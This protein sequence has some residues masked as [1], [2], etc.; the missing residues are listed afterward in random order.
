M[1]AHPGDPGETS[2]QDGLNYL[3]K[4]V[5]GAIVVDMN[6]K[7][8]GRN[9]IFR[10]EAARVRKTKTWQPGQI[11]WSRPFCDSRELEK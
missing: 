7:G 2:A 1:L 5:C 11:K 8:G 10:L 6:M 9:P 4:T 3:G